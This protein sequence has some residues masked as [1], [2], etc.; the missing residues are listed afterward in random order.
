MPLY[1]WQV[2]GK[3]DGVP[4]SWLWSKRKSFKLT[5]RPNSAGM[6]PGGYKT[7]S[8][9]TKTKSRFR[10]GTIWLR[11]AS[12][13]LN[14]EGKSVGKRDGVPVSWLLYNSSSVNCA[15]WPNSAGMG[16]GVYK[17]KSKYTKNK[18]CYPTG[19]KGY[20]K[21]KSTPSSEKRGWLHSR[22][23]PSK[24]QQL[25]SSRK[26]SRIIWNGYLDNA[27]GNRIIYFHA[28]PCCACKN[29]L[30]LGTGWLMQNRWAHNLSP[31]LW[32]AQS[33]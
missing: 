7:Q 18:S 13:C 10:T 15:I 17:I 11:N 27:F 20:M 32:W 1:W 21:S 8:N 25:R 28:P 3:R 19:T 29:K 14:I 6:G 2:R 9:H 24:P 33:P 23:S 22:N 30:S 16:P 26:M 5:N 12:L 31:G 4:V